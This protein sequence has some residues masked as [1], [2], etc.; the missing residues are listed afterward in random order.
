MW[1]LTKDPLNLQ[2]V[3]LSQR[4][5][6]LQR[7]I[8]LMGLFCLVF[9][10]WGQQKEIVG[11]YPSWKWN[12]KNNLVTPAML[13]FD[14]LT[15][16]NY[17]FFY[18]L[19]DG[20]L[21]GRDTIG[22]EMYLNGARAHEHGL[23]QSGIS[24]IPLAHHHNVKVLLSIGGWE[25][26]GNFPAVAANLASTK[27]F[28]HSCAEVIR[29]FGFDGIDIDWEYPCYA[30]HKGTSADKVNFT[31][32]LKISRDSLTACGNDQGKKLLLTAALPAGASLASNFEIEKIADILDMLNVMTYDFSGPWDSVS[33][34]NSPLH[35][36]RKSDSTWNVDAAFH[37]YTRIYGVLPGKVNIGIPFFGHAFA[38]CT[39][40]GSS[41]AGADTTYF[42]EGCLYINIVSMMDKFTR[43]WDEVA[44]VP[45]LVSLVSKTLV[46]YDDEESVG[47][48]AQ[49]A[50][51][52][53][54]G[55]VIIWEITG[56]HLSDGRTP[57]LDVIV[58]KFRGE[59]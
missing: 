57:L 5:K 11:Y 56:D 44:K 53:H 51:D 46:S 25:D 28:A 37:L 15:M 26:S 36:T 20:R 42:S 31:R 19:P 41:H 55:G 54:A 12:S 48:K 3:K 50:L 45:Y 14:K 13:P 16:I 8:L 1:L 9:R 10:I 30:E 4:S 47:Y 18:P 58:S 6:S 49:Y 43:Y 27:Q 22:D 24:L 23:S 52:Q 59:K 40:I 38:G 33:G 2:E 7:S 39:S 35:A 29:K 32:L 17:A 34:H 21:I